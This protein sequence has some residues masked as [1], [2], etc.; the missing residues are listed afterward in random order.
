MANQDNAADLEKKYVDNEML[1]SCI[2][3]YAAVYDKSCRDYKIPLKKKKAWKEIGIDWAEAQ[4][5]H[6]S[7]RTNF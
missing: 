4:T 1:M 2:R 3:K 6:N 7:I 5:H